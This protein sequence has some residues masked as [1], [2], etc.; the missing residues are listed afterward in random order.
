MLVISATL[1]LL[2]L[3]IGF[4]FAMATSRYDQRKLFEQD[5]ADAIGTEYV[6]ADL[7]PAADAHAVRALLVEYLDRRIQYY[8]ASRSADLTDLNAA[9]RRLQGQL[10][11]ALLEPAAAQP[12]PPM[13]LVLGGM[14]EVL[15]R[16]GYTQFAWLNR[17]PV[18]AWALMITI[19]L[20]ANLLIGYAKQQSSGGALLL[21]LPVIVSVS[22][23]LVADIDSPRGGVIRTEPVD[24]LSLSQ[25]L[26]G[27]P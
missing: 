10:W 2:G 21:V 24:L 7:L 19:A 20:F 9:T 12:T 13:A 6:R 16:E 5:E 26:H 4:T 1:T 15:N 3:I 18:A 14:N 11:S 25:S 23:F 17:I 22:F 8:E 27:R